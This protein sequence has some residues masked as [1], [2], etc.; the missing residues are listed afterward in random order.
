M[1]HKQKRRNQ[2]RA[3]KQANAATLSSNRP[4]QNKPLDQQ[5]PGSQNNANAESEKESEKTSQDFVGAFPQEISVHDMPPVHLIA[6][7]ETPSVFSL[8][9]RLSPEPDAIGIGESES[10]NDQP[11]QHRFKM[12]S[13]SIWT[14]LLTALGTVIAIPAFL[15]AWKE[16][17]KHKQLRV[18]YYAKAPL[19][20]SEFGLVKDFKLTHRGHLVTD[21][22]RL[23]IAIRNTG[24]MPIKPSDVTEPVV[25]R[26]IK[27][28]LDAQI[29]SK[30]PTDIKQRIV[31]EVPAQSVGL[32]TSVV[33]TSDTIF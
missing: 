29:V 20:S 5:H 9:N 31:S 4:S 16:L 2:Q 14:L 13:I 10:S 21:P 12:P 6:Q 3:R 32:T 28:V 7:P 15:I 24:T 22:Y 18:Q 11:K 27:K 26:F 30:I 23:M 25:F 8:P 1:S 33:G 17:T 19:L